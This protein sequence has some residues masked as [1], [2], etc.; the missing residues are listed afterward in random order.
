MA[1]TPF[2]LTV[3]SA[4]PANPLTV[5]AG[6][7][8]IVTWSHHTQ[9]AGTLHT[10]AIGALSGAV[11]GP[12]SYSKADLMVGP[13]MPMVLIPAGIEALNSSGSDS[14]VTST[15]VTATANAAMIRGWLMDA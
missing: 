9:D 6:K 13:M 1:K 7:N 10:A 2:M 4:S 14:R 12:G 5:P 11:F 8:L 3:T 15:T